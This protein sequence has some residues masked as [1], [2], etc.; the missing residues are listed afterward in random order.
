MINVYMKRPHTS[1]YNIT[2]G[3]TIFDGRAVTV[4]SVS[5]GRAVNRK[6]VLCDTMRKGNE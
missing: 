1:K 5:S 4:R 2:Y 6:V 3:I